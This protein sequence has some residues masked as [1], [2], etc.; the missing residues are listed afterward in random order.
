MEL[1][2]VLT[3]KPGTFFEFESE[4][5]SAQVLRE[6]LA[7]SLERKDLKQLQ[8]ALRVITALYLN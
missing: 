2:K 3:V 7:R 6:K 4:E 5:M 1:S 8:L